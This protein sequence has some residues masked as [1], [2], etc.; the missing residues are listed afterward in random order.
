MPVSLI[1]KRNYI[2]TFAGEA[3]VLG[4]SGVYSSLSRFC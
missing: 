2:R 1:I 4:Y 3:I